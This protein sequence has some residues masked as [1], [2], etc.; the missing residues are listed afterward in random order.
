MQLR[1]ADINSFQFT[2]LSLSA[3]EGECSFNQTSSDQN[4]TEVNSGTGDWMG[5]HQ[6]WL[7]VIWF[8]CCCSISK[9]QLV[10]LKHQRAKSFKLKLLKL[11]VMWMFSFFINNNDVLN[12]N[13]SVAFFVKCFFQYGIAWCH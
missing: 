11:C 7:R 6:C 13:V 8:S 5:Y 2:W 10:I 9:E 12:L 3:C 1:N 4:Q